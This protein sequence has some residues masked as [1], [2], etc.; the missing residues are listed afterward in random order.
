MHSQ[1]CDSW[2]PQEPKFMTSL[3][4]RL[5]VSTREVH[6]KA[7]RS[8]LMTALVRGDMARAAYRELLANLQTIYKALEYELHRHRGR[9]VISPLMLDGLARSD[10]IASDLAQIGV[11]HHEPMMLTTAASD[12]VRRLHQI[13]EQAPALLVAHSYVRYLGDLYGGQ[14]LAPIV[15]E[16]LGVPTS[17]YDFGGPRKVAELMSAYRHQLDRLPVTEEDAD[18]IVAEARSAFERH[19]AMFEELAS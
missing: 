14:M 6:A 12:Y 18:A 15:A 3:A 8:T 2:R 10:A 16:R 5:R 7:E 4:Q 13:G 1:T 11:D 17:F 19:V 9:P